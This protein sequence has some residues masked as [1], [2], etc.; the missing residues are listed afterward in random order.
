MTYALVIDNEIQAVGRLPGSARLVATGV[1]F[2]PHGG[3]VNASTAEQEACGWF[4]VTDTPPSYN[5][6]T[7]VLTRGDV[8]LVAGR[9]VR[10]YTKRAKTA[11][12][13]AADAL[14]AA[15]EQ[16]TQTLANPTTI[17][18]QLTALKAFLV[19]TDIQVVLDQANNTALTTAQLN[20]A[21]KAIVRQLRRQANMTVRLSR[22]TCG[23]VNPEL[24]GDVSD[25]GEA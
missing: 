5:T 9:P 24:L 23:E 21:L 20:R 19:D 1:W 11:E 4:A 22:L 16:N 7:E 18:A 2:C 10:Q 3:L 6:A 15:V 17:E 14:A 13:L 8:I 25:V 12:E